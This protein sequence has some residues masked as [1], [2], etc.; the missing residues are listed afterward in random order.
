MS[1]IAPCAARNLIDASPRLTAG[2]HRGLS[3]VIERIDI[4]AFNDTGQTAI[5][6]GIIQ[7]DAS[8]KFLA[9]LS[10]ILDMKDERGR[11]PLDLA[12]QTPSQTKFRP[13]CGN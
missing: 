1:S 2:V 3:R 8:I 5:R 13:W 7:G 12:L 9:A 10:T 6:A 11:T 4:D